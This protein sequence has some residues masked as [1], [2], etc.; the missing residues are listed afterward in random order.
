MSVSVSVS[1][2]FV[3]A[4]R[5]NRLVQLEVEVDDSVIESV[6]NAKLALAHD[7]AGKHGTPA[8]AYSHAIPC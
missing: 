4:A 3:Q 1:V 6:K 5:R 8:A 7:H 2:V